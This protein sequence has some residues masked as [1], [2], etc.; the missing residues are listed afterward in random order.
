[1][2]HEL[3]QWQKR[4]KRQQ[5]HQQMVNKRRQHRHMS[6]STRAEACKKEHKAQGFDKLKSKRYGIRVRMVQPQQHQVEVPG[7]DGELPDGLSFKPFKPYTY[8]SPI[9]PKRMQQHPAYVPKE[10]QMI[11]RDVVKSVTGFHQMMT[12]SAGQLGRNIGHTVLPQRIPTNDTV[13]IKS[14]YAAK[15][16]IAT[17]E[18]IRRIVRVANALLRHGQKALALF[19]ATATPVNLHCL[20][21][22]IFHKHRHC[23]V[24]VAI[25]E[26]ARKRLAKLG[27]VDSSTNGS[28][29]NSS[30]IQS[31]A[32]IEPISEQE[33]EQEQD[34]LLSNG[35]CPEEEADE[36]G[37]KG[38][39]GG[40]FCSL[41]QYLRTPTATIKY[42]NKHIALIRPI[43]L[44]YTQTCPLDGA[45]FKILSHGLESSIVKT[46]GVSLAVQVRRYFIDIAAGLRASLPH[47]PVRDGFIFLSETDLWPHLFRSEHIR[48]YIRLTI[49]EDP[50][51]IDIS[52]KS[53]GWLLTSLITPVGGSMQSPVRSHTGHVYNNFARVTTTATIE[54]L[55]VLRE[56]IRT[57]A[58]GDESSSQFLMDQRPNK[59]RVVINPK[60]GQPTN[61]L[62]SYLLR[63]MIVTNGRSLRLPVVDLR[64]R[65]GK[66]FM[67]ELITDPNDGTV[68]RRHVL[69]PDPYRRLPSLVTAIP[70]QAIL[71]RLFPD[72]SK[73]DVGAIDLGKEFMAA[74][75]CRRYNRADFI[76]TVHAKTKAAYQ[77]TTKAAKELE[78]CL[79]NGTIA[80]VRGN[81]SAIAVYES[82]LPS[83]SSDPMRRVLVEQTDEYRQYAAFYNNHGRQQ[84]RREQAKRARCGEFDVLTNH[85]LT[86]MGT[87]RV[88]A[89]DP[90]RRGLILIGLGGFSATSKGHRTS[91]HNSFLRHFLPRV[92]ISIPDFYIPSSSVVSLNGL[93]PN[94]SLSISSSRLEALDMSCLE[95]TS[96]TPLG[97]V[98]L[99]SALVRMPGTLLATLASGV[100]I[101]PAVA[102]GFI[103]IFWPPP[104][105]W[106]QGGTTCSTFLG[107]CTSFQSPKM[108][109]GSTIHGMAR[110]PHPRCQQGSCSTGELTR[111]KVRHGRV[112]GT[113]T[114]LDS[115]LPLL[116]YAVFFLV[117]AASS[118]RRDA[119]RHCRLS[120]TI[121]AIST[122]SRFPDL[123]GFG[124][125]TLILHE[126]NTP[127]GHM[128]NNFLTLFRFFLIIFLSHFVSF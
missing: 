5:Q 68:Y 64:L 42:N 82:A 30:S 23:T 52:T 44:Q 100:P 74:F 94:F 4:Q 120:T 34:N 83:L 27:K 93:E 60:P 97:A 36:S 87:H 26:A 41:L 16:G 109:S 3:D 51:F 98:P 118:R 7:N 106:K 107:Q 73:V 62:P 38:D 126:P 31:L 13:D 20:K 28:S 111:D 128:Y 63:G 69:A 90:D 59:D 21:D 99:A 81:E 117:F 17:T 2:G 80:C 57:Q 46:L 77:P 43:R 56:A 95:L 8:V 89:Q 1:M 24:E 102:R 115:R 15:A 33:E 9:T 104:I 11:K 116:N 45:D 105:W 70:D 114:V 50:E 53:P 37:T 65:K 49:G 71:S 78:R 66:R 96:S 40:F 67:M 48:H 76:Y 127:T 18:T 113:L 110:F 12:L 108:E 10:R 29:S 58:I 85:I 101:V 125:S 75:A 124:V 25:S 103:G 6:V 88:R 47:S 22:T 72:I 112:N 55:N 32:T 119:G 122:N 121:Y 91:L 14:H 84:K 79:D 54:E 92:S 35:S 39:H 19:I 86:A 123:T 61:L